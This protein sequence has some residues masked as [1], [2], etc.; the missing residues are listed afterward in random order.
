MRIGAFC[1][2]FDGVELGE[3]KWSG[4]CWSKFR[5]L[6]GVCVFVR[7]Y[8]GAVECHNRALWHLAR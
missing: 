4:V 7:V 8:L 2:G 3:L 5:E 6:V 1:D